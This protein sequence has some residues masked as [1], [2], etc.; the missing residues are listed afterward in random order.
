[1]PNRKGHA[2][3]RIGMLCHSTEPRGRLSHALALA[4][5]L[6]ERGHDVVVHAPDPDL[7]GFPRAARC[8]LVSVP[9]G[10]AP[11]RRAAAGPDAGLAAQRIAELTGYFR[12][13][14]AGAFDCLHAHD[15]VSAHALR[16]LRAEERIPGFV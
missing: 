12:A 4:E 6:T 14:D 2:R 5:A 3:L 11:T 8:G 9:A 13:I 15:C 16:T 10:T 1:M 7:S